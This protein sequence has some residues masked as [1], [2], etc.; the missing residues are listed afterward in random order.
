MRAGTGPRIRRDL[1]ALVICGAAYLTLCV[2]I[3]NSYYQLM[4]TLV[5]IWAAMGLSWNLIS[6]YSGLVSFGHAAFFGLGA[7]S[8]TLALVY[9]N[10]TPWLGIPLGMLVGAV[11]AVLIGVPTFRLRG[12]YFALSMLAY[13]LAI[14][15]VLEF[16]GFQEVPLPMHRQR[17]GLF[18]QFTDPRLYTIVAV[19]VVAI[20]MLV[21]IAVENSRFGLALT[22]IRQNELAAE[23]AGIDTWRWKMRGLVVS[24]A[25]AAA[26]GGLYACVLLVVTPD[27]VF[28][29]LVSAQALVVTL[30]GGVATVWGPV[31]GAAILIPLAE[32]LN[33]R[34]GNI[35]PGIQGVVYGAAIIAIMLI[36]P[37]GLFWTVRDLLSRTSSLRLREGD[38]EKENGAARVPPDPLP[39]GEA[40]RATALLDVR[41]L[42]RSFGGLRALDNVSFSIETGEILGIIGPNGAGKTTLFNVLNGVLTADAGEARLAGSPM[43]RHKVHQI[44]RMGIGRTFQVVRSFP[45]L[46]LLDNVIVG[47][48]GAGLDDHAAVTAA[49]AALDA[50]DLGRLAARTASQLTNKEL[51]LMELARAL[52]GR[53]RLLLLDETLAGLGREECDELLHVLHGLRQ[54]G[55]TIVIIEHTMHAMLRLADRFLVLDHGA[56]LAQGSPRDVIENRAVIEAYL[57]PKFLAQQCSR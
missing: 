45:R 43:L 37:Q 44:A 11:A 33:A 17:P 57:G 4:L 24:G 13:P 36:A 50:V 8:V 31:I 9:L 3:H 26:A 12:H 51:R 29:V 22:A 14:L 48:Y 47:A 40:G 52:A 55:I 41:N 34:L 53:P 21:S 5:T 49:T 56:V 28:G 2:V 7:Y 32:T 54:A 1:I 46:S 25:M 10:L 18:M 19:G 38:K 16:L 39:R 6:G 35:I 23:A 20:A 15:Y 42:S 27:S 30:F